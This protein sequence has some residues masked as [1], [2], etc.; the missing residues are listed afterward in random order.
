MN[1]KEV[2]SEIEATLGHIPIVFRAIP[3]S[4][5]E[6]EWEIYKKLQLEEGLI[7]PKYRAFIGLAIAALTRCPYSNYYYT[8]NARLNGSS[9]EEI[10][11]VVHF[12]KTASS[13]S[14]YV[15]GLQIPLPL[16]KKEIDQIN[17]HIKKITKVHI[18][19]E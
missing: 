1:R 15:N 6:Y 8:E 5:L 17:N 9:N 10:E 11:A 14:T 18:M 19:S 16:Y 3:D 12:T 7:P 2:L 13:W 4:T